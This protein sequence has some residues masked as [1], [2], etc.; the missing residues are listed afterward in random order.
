M[1]RGVD[2]VEKIKIQE[3][4]STQDSRVE[5]LA[6]DYFNEGLYCS[7]ALLRAFN[8]VYD[9]GL[10]P[11]AYKIATGFGSGMGETGC[12]CGAVTSCVMVLGLVAGRNHKSESEAL[13]YE[14]VKNL[15]EEF[16][17]TFKST[18][19]RVLTKNIEW[20]S[21]AHNAQCENMVAKAA[22]ITQNIL[23]TDLKDYL[24]ENGAK[25]IPKKWSIRRVRRKVRETFNHH[26]SGTK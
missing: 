16:R 8:E 11:S 13:V 18:C 4:A 7:E 24:P 10:P 19:C 21:K 22:E 12:A 2:L 17:G 26:F 9:L 15:Q 5:L 20:G 1:Q 25:K 3:V 6:R 14:G 23:E